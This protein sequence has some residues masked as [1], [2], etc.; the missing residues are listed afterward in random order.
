MEYLKNTLECYLLAIIGFLIICFVAS[1][2]YNNGIGV[3]VFS[4]LAILYGFIMMI[5]A[6]KTLINA[7]K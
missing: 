6:N 2:T 7:E 3:L 1:Q 4:I 5:D